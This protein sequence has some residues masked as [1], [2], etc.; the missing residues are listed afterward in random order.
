ML[1]WTCLKNAASARL[2]RLGR[3]GLRLTAGSNP[4]VEQVLRSEYLHYGDAH[5]AGR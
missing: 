5:D 2:A 3:G 1:N 4:F